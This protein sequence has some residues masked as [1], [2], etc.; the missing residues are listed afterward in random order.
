MCHYLIDRNLKSNFVEERWAYNFSWVLIISLCHMSIK[1]LHYRKSYVNWCNIHLR[2]IFG[3]RTAFIPTHLILIIHRNKKFT[4]NVDMID[5]ILTKSAWMH[6]NDVNIYK[7]HGNMNI[8]QR[9]KFHQLSKLH[10]TY[11]RDA[12]NVIVRT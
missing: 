8:H 5:M 10:F 9:I 11:R 1:I 3:Q 7:N 12:C 4:V 2:G 6:Q